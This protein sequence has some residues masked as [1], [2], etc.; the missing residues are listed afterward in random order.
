MDSTLPRTLGAARPTA[1]RSRVQEHRAQRGWGDA[2]DLEKSVP[3]LVRFARWRWVVLTAGRS[4]SDAV[5]IRTSL[6][7]G[8]NA[9][10][11]EFKGRQAVEWGLVTGATD[12]FVGLVRR[13][14]PDPFN[15]FEHAEQEGDA[16]QFVGTQRG[17]GT[18]R[19][20]AQGL[21]RDRST[22]EVDLLGLAQLPGLRQV[23]KSPH[24]RP[25]VARP[26]LGVVDRGYGLHSNSPV[27]TIF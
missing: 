1:A 22:Q 24:S 19:P 5:H 9:S 15:A 26:G 4:T 27:V 14:A 17:W 2:T 3:S 25:S 23:E 18:D 12:P 11:H 10:A 7:Q 8:R 6:L 16:H 20:V 21:S 13:M